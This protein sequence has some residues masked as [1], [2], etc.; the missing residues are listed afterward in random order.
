MWSRLLGRLASAGFDDLS[1]Q[2]SGV[3]RVLFGVLAVLFGSRDH[4]DVLV[5]PEEP[6]LVAGLGELVVVGHAHGLVLA[7][8]NDFVAESWD[9]S[10][11][12]TSRFDPFFV[13]DSTSNV[14]PGGSRNSASPLP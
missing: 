11:I 3:R 5:R 13:T 6:V 1:E 7:F 9:T 12:F 10:R 4:R 2:A 8:V 14:A